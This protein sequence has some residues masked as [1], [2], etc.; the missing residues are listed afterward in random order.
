[1]CAAC[2]GHVDKLSFYQLKS[3]IVVRQIEQLFGGHV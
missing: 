2:R 1:M 3:T